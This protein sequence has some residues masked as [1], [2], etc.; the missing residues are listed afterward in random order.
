MYG[1]PILSPMQIKLCWLRSSLLFCIVNEIAAVHVYYMVDCHL[2]CMY[3]L[4]ECF[5]SR[6]V[7][8][9][10]AL[11]CAII[12]SC[13]AT[14]CAKLSLVFR[15]SSHSDFYHTS[16]CR[17][18]RLGKLD[19]HTCSIWWTHEGWCPSK[20]LEIILW[21]INPRQG[22]EAGP[23]SMTGNFPF[24][25]PPPPS[26]CG[27]TVIA[28]NFVQDKLIP[29]IKFSLVEY[30]ASSAQLKNCIFLVV[31]VVACRLF[32]FRPR[33]Q[34]REIET[35]AHGRGVGC[36]LTTL[37]ELYGLEAWVRKEYVLW[38][39][40]CRLRDGLRWWQARG[41]SSIQEFITVTID[42]IFPFKAQRSP[43]SI[44]EGTFVTVDQFMTLQSSLILSQDPVSHLLFSK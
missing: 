24:L 22:L 2:T 1:A 35:S 43:Q 17:K 6:S 40:H 4:K 8:P 16:K 20:D 12:T 5:T 41:V 36:S 32:P 9:I 38:F 33:P 31:V 37:R 15:N 28:I 25:L 34:A 30:T 39:L 19:M 23:G 11:W 7:M 26:P 42:I 21:H 13:I 18:G 29:G 14:L 44:D 27:N 3:S 10:L